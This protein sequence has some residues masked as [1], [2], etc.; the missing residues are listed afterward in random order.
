MAWPLFFFIAGLAA[1]SV[2]CLMPARWCPPLPNDKLM[3]FAAFGTLA[4]LS[5]LLT[6]SLSHLLLLQLGLLMVGGLIEMLQ[7]WVPGRD[8]CWRDLLANTAGIVLATVLLIVFD[9]FR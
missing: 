4:L 3:H 1:V 6:H 9:P 7:T 8:F 2:G 5:G